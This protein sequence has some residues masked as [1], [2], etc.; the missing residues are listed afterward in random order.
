VVM[1]LSQDTRDLHFDIYTRNRILSMAFFDKYLEFLKKVFS[2]T[3][4][5]M[6]VEFERGDPQLVPIGE[7]DRQEIEREL[8]SG[9]IYIEDV[10]TSS[11]STHLS[12]GGPF[13]KISAA[14]DQELIGRSQFRSGYIALIKLLA[15]VSNADLVF[16][17]VAEA[18]GYDTSY[19]AT[20]L[21]IG[22]GL[23]DVYW[24]NIY[25]REFANLIGRDKL[26]GLPDCTAEALD[27]GS[28][29]VQISNEPLCIHRKE[30]VKEHIGL[31]YFVKNSHVPNTE[32]VVKTGIV[33]LVRHLLT[34]S[35]KS[36][37][38]TAQAE[39][40][41]IFFEAREN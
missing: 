18:P 22:A 38:D 4:I 1:I 6:L 12:E 30:S 25:G 21:S 32:A 8:D 19:G 17:Y 24:L 29:Y 7:V 3:Q 28:I 39:K 27:D 11:F 35:G 31:Q 33:A 41:P 13:N 5:A 34:V 9:S 20:P 15:T 36:S 40:T 26:L 23:R 10:G 37:G 2:N 16:S 14:I